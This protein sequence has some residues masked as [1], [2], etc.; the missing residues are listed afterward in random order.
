M[1]LVRFNNTSGRQEEY[2]YMPVLA[3]VRSDC[4]DP[5]LAKNDEMLKIFNQKPLENTSVHI[6]RNPERPVRVRAP[7][8]GTKERDRAAARRPDMCSFI[9]YSCRQSWDSQKETIRRPT[10]FTVKMPR[11]M[12][13]SASSTFHRLLGNCFS[14][15]DPEDALWLFS[16]NSDIRRPI[17]FFMTSINCIQELLLHITPGYYSHFTSRVG[18]ERVVQNIVCIMLEYS[19]SWS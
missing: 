11:V 16:H 5:G 2:S 9:V 12:F 4:C 3:V 14:A 17:I 6:K 15:D 13:L 7:G 1:R 19:K 10:S 18:T 8:P